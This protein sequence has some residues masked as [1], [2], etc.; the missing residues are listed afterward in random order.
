MVQCST[1]KKYSQWK[2]GKGW[3]RELRESN[4]REKR[5]TKQKPSIFEIQQYLGKVLGKSHIVVDTFAM[6][7]QKQVTF[8]GIY[9]VVTC[10]S[11]KMETLYL[12][13][14]SLSKL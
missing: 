5:T 13:V 12:E 8:V 10:L 3:M 6:H 4:H 7:A 11:Y 14:R 9:E 1:P 2:D